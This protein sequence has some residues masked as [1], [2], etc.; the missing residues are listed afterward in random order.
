MF[1][2]TSRNR[3]VIPVGPKGTN[4]HVFVFK[5][6]FYLHPPD[7]T[8]L[9]RALPG[10]RVSEYKIGGR[11]TGE[12][13][14]VVWENSPDNLSIRHDGPEIFPLHLPVNLIQA[15]DQVF[16]GGYQLQQIQCRYT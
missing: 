6:C 3:S 10:P 16:H 11:S 4:R 8:W 7:P 14:P 12:E 5:R 13:M 15:A 1:D 9:I 2:F